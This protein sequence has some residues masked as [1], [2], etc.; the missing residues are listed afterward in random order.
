MIK[1]GT[2]LFEAAEQ[3]EREKG[4]SKEKILEQNLV[5]LLYTNYNYSISNEMYQKLGYDSKGYL[6][7]FQIKR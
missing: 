4:I 6:I 7:N 5:P 1:I 2:A 3:F